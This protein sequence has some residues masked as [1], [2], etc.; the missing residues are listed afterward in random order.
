MPRPTSAQLRRAKRAHELEWRD[1]VLRVADNGL[2]EAA[3]A[4][5]R[6]PHSVRIPGPKTRPCARQRLSR[7]LQV[8]AR[9]CSATTTMAKR[10]YSLA[11]WQR[12]RALVFGSRRC[13]WSAC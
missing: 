4:L 11:A 10:L 8:C 2:Q 13:A 7:S 1:R 3:K 9:S 5:C 6:A 12:V